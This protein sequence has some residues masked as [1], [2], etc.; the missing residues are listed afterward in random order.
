MTKNKYQLL[1]ELFGDCKKFIRNII[2][3]HLY[4][5]LIIK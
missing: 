2:V 1:L 3:S 4:N 5:N